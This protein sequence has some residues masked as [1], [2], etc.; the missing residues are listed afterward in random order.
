M[1]SDAQ[2]KNEEIR[3]RIAG[4]P[5]ARIIGLKSDIQRI[6][7]E[8][9][10]QEELLA[11][12]EVQITDVNQR[13]NSVPP[14]EVALESLNREYLTQKANYDA[15][16]KKSQD[17]ELIANVNI[18]AQNET[19]QVVDAANLPER[20]VAPKRPLLMALGLGAGL[21]VGLF[22]AAAFE[23][24]RLLTIQT[25]DDAEHYT[26]LPVLV[27]VPELLT[28]QEARRVPMRRRLALAAG[29]IAT[30]VSIPALALL[31]RATHVFDRFLG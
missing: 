31:L 14:A 21:A 25:T 4:R 5:D 3:R 23:V 24:P 19:I 26:G 27:S 8:I 6:E 17:A 29:I 20:P 30:I 12:S 1:V 9:K 7:G 22:L 11:Q 13:I 18:N 15:L 28:P 2:A 10:R 16:L